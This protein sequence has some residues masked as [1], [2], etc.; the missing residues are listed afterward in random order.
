MDLTNMVKSYLN[1]KDN[2]TAKEEAMRKKLS[3]EKL[4]QSKSISKL[5]LCNDF[6]EKNTD[7]TV[8]IYEHLCKEHKEN[9]LKILKS[10]AY[11]FT[12]INFLKVEEKLELVDNIILPYLLKYSGK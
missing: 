8:E 4:I 6:I 9:K 3:P 11:F 12:D 7:H 1:K 2:E 10:F 5:L